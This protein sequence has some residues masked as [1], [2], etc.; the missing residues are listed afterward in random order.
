MAAKGK[1]A[2]LPVGEHGGAWRN[3][4]GHKVREENH[5]A[6]VEGQKQGIFIRVGVACKLDKVDNG[7]NLFFSDCH[8]TFDVLLHSGFR[9]SDQTFGQY[10]VVLDLVVKRSV[11]SWLNVRT[12]VNLSSVVPH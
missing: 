9:V 8:Q 11:C 5:Y 12:K 7:L 10:L 2:K 3:V 4:R 1:R 6:R